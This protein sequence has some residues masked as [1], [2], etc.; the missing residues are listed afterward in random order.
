MDTNI[1]NS[2][3]ELTHV[4]SNNITVPYTTFICKPG[5]N[6]TISS[7]IIPSNTY[8]ESNISVIESNNTNFT[9]WSNTA[10][11]KDFK[12]NI[13][14]GIL[15]FY[16]KLYDN[17]ALKSGEVDVYVNGV[18]LYNLLAS[19]GTF[20]GVINLT[21]G[22]F[23]V[24]FEPFSNNSFGQAHT[25]YFSYEDVRF[26]ETGLTS[27]TLWNVTLNGVKKSSTASTIAFMESNGTYSYTISNIS[28][29]TVSPSSGNITVNG[30]NITKVIIYSQNPTEKSPTPLFGMGIYT[31]G[32]ITIFIIAIGAIII[33]LRKKK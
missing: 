29:Y 4:G 20:N 8:I 21:E 17:Y 18:S 25:I 2:S 31:I 11:L 23:L 33:G 32:L 12:Y 16:G 9:K 24:T 3:F 22:N 28:G 10:I 13:T 6:A 15:N 5:I 7:G 26:T 14:K 19:N 30:S 27:G 1:T